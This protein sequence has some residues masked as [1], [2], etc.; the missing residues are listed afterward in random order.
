MFK[1]ASEGY[2]YFNSIDLHLDLIRFYYRIISL[3]FDNIHRYPIVNPTFP[4]LQQR[5]NAICQNKY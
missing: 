4:K 2:D 1:L 3:Y 5:N